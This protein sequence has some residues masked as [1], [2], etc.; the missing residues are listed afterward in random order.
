[1]DGLPCGCW[2]GRWP[3]LPWHPLLYGEQRPRHRGKLRPA[4]VLG[5]DARF[6]TRS[7]HLAP[8]GG[9]I[10]RQARLPWRSEVVPDSCWATLLAGQSGHARGRQAVR[11]RA[12]VPCGV[13]CSVLRTPV[14][15]T[16]AI[17]MLH[18]GSPSGL[19][20]AGVLIGYVVNISAVGAGATYHRIAEDLA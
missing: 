8:T 13:I 5:R 16:A 17:T 4:Q 11:E 3:V 14:S 19:V 20:A 12:T 7:S 1:M 9:Y 18:H 15:L 10:V 6:L 2:V